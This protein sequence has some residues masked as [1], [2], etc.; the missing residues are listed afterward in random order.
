MII[1]QNVLA[2][3]AVMVFAVSWWRTSERIRQI[4]RQ[5]M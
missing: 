1:I 2:F 4:V 5:D 3:K